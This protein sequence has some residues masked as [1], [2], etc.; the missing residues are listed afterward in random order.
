MAHGKME[1][2]ARR[3]TDFLRVVP[4]LAAGVLLT[5]G[6]SGVPET[7]AGVSLKI[8]NATAPP[9]GTMQL[10]VSLT[11]PK[12]ISTGS[13]ALSLDGAVLGPVMGVALYGPGGS[14]SDAVGAAV[15]DGNSIVVRTVSPSS[16]FGLATTVPILAVTIGVSPAALP[17]AQA[18]LLLDPAA[19]V[20]IDPAGVPYAQEVKD[21]SF[22]VAGTV[23]ISDVIPGMGLLPAGSTVVVRGIGFKPGAIVE[24]DGVSLASAAVV[25]DTEVDLT[26]GVSADLY[27]RRVTIKNPDL[28][29]ANY[30][31]YLRAAWLGRSARTLLARTDPIF[32][33]QTF[34][35]A[36]FTPST[37]PG[38]FFGLALQNP[39]ADAA[40]ATI[41]LRSTSAGSIATATLTLPARTRMT[42]EAS[43]LF[44][45]QSIP[46]DG[47]LVVR[48]NSPVQMLGLLGD[49]AAGTVE[50]IPAS[51]AFR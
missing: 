2:R 41:E 37:A 33:P 8:L 14:L 21:G 27:G 45:G 1:R 12:P 36:F 48:S 51:L 18:K 19:S 25:S 11:E 6:H 49:E 4:C 20:W 32:S 16:D 42:R 9:G 43:E 5:A 13:A 50:P 28:S 40:D 46:A 38:Q 23:S 44:A 24:V 7:F 29:R 26:L 15:V 47:S 17:G 34:T 22:E 3:T 35:G 30:R 31:A 10:T 39:A